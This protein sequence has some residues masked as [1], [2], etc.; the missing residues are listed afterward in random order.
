MGCRCCKITLL[1]EI[2]SF[3]ASSGHSLLETLIRDFK[4]VFDLSFVSFKLLEI[5]DTHDAKIFS[6]CRF[7]MLAKRCINFMQ[8]FLHQ[9]ILFEDLILNVRNRSY[10]KFFLLLS[11]NHRP[12]N[13]LTARIFSLPPYAVA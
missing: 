11:P 3:C 13:C 8:G 1:G 4:I 7:Q 2:F 12:F 5:A 6:K 9:E 10:L